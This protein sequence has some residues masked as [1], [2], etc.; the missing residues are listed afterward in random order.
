MTGDA[1][2]A[3][4]AA[5][6][7]AKLRM[8]KESPATRRLSGMHVAELAV[9][10][11]VYF[12]TV[13]AASEAEEKRLHFALDCMERE[14]PSFHVIYD[15][16]DN[17]GQTI[18]QGMGELHLD[19]IRDRIDKEYKLQAFFGP[20]NIAY[21]EMPTC[22]ASETHLIEKSLPTA[23]GGDERKQHVRIDLSVMPSEAASSSSSS[24]STF[25]SV[26]LAAVAHQRGVSE[27][28]GLVNVAPDVLASINHGVRL[29]LGK[30]VLLRYPMVNTSVR[31]DAFNANKN[32]SLPLVSTCAY[33]CTLAALRK[34]EC[35]VIQPIMHVEIQT[36]REYAPRVYSDLMRK[37]ATEVRSS[38]GDEESHDTGAAVLSA[39]VPLAMLGS[40]S[41]ELRKLTSGNTSFT[42]QFANYEPLSQRE[43]QDLA[44]KRHV[45]SR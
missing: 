13:E 7:E 5:H 33:Q 37:N 30:G 8:S 14:D 16:A 42:I 32:I 38:G 18:V 43:Y 44:I 19:I 45:T 24:S 23:N 34:A 22:P 17:M 9:A 36:T 29:A 1:L 21:K 12:C 41:S 26:E 27:S 2:V 6:D 25:T 15:D 39:N 11:P 28:N 4:K 40:Y 35:V 20:L 3:S 31:L 10:P